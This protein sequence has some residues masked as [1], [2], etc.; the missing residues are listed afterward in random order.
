MNT[1]LT[2]RIFST[3]A[4]T[5]AVG[6]AAAGLAAILLLV[7]LNRYRSSLNEVNAPVTVLVA[8]SLIPK[9]TPGN[10]IGT[11]ALYQA[12]TVAKNQLKE[13]ALVDPASL[14]NAVALTDIYPG[15]QLTVGQFVP[16]VVGAATA[17]ITAYERAISIPVDP[18]HGLLSQVTAGD[19][20]DIL[21][22]FN[23]RRINADGTPAPNAVE[24]PVIKTLMQ[25]V[26]VLAVPS[27]AVT[28]RVNDRQAA[29]LA[30]A[31]DNGKLWV[32]LRPPAGARETKPSFVTLES[33]LFGV[34]PV[35]IARSF[36][37]SR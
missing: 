37:A 1:T 9:G 23:V 28:V 14:R 30:F 25:D 35:A 15:Q 6:L 2:A 34:P 12:T 22:G 5:I 16:T 27:G 7:F 11:S 36:G 21:G 8:K 24:R 26:L 13:G 4:G 20:V 18:T 3:R 31:A 33:V 29:K 19:R 17:S 10:V 32:T